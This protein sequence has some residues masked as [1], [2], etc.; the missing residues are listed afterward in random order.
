MKPNFVPLCLFSQCCSEVILEADGAW[1][2]RKGKSSGPFNA[3]AVLNNDRGITDWIA[4]C[5]AD[6]DKYSLLKSSPTFYFFIIQYSVSLRNISQCWSELLVHT[7]SHLP[8]LFKILQVKSSHFN[9]NWQ[10]ENVAWWTSD[11][12]EVSLCELHVKFL[13]TLTHVFTASTNSM[14]LGFGSELCV[15]RDL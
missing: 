4:E 12:Q 6:M 5:T 9:G 7:P 13:Q 8:L 11:G 1:R 14:P 2:E 15:D 10:D 3:T